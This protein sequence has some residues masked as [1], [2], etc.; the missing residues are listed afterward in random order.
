MSAQ[1]D[2]IIEQGESFSQVI[3]WQTGSSL[4]PVNLTG[5]TAKMQIRDSADNALLTLTETAGITL[6]GAAGTI[7]ITLTEEQTTALLIP[8]ARYDLFLYGSSDYKKKL[9]KGTVTVTFSETN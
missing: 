2:L 5:M 3:T 4:V 7:V 6:G 1:Y 8:I 9:L